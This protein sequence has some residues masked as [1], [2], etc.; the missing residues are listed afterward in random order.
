MVTIDPSLSISGPRRSEDGSVRS[1]QTGGFGNSEIGS[2]QVLQEKKGVYRVTSVEF[3]QR[4]HSFL[5]MKFRAA[6][7]ETRKALV[8]EK[9]GNLTRA[10][11]KNKLDP[12]HHDLARNTLW[13]YSP[14]MLFSREVAPDEWEKFILDYESACKPLYQDEFRDS[15]F[16][17][18][19]VAKK[20]NGDDSNL[21]TSQTE[22][23]TEGLATTTARRL[24]VKRSQTLAK[25]RSPTGDGGNKSG[26]DKADGR[27]PPSEVFSGALDEMVSIMSMEQNFIVE[28]FHVTSLGQHDFVDSVAAAPPDLRR[29]AD[30]RRAKVM[31][32]N[33]ILAKRVVQTMEEIYAF[34]AGDMEALVDWSLQSDPL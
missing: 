4:L 26:S 3:L 19:R 18:K 7:D 20:G 34:W 21:F 12:H 10:A 30:L 33:R 2:M 5:Q 9:G 29:G 15:V 27:L 8:R 24:T 31:D 11:G 16:A 23:P 22:K 17:W 25:I 28:F 32:P 14:L 6:I 1:G 13:R